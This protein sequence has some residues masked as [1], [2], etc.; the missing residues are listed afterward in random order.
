MDSH[1]RAGISRREII[2]RSAVAGGLVWTAPVI[3]D[4]LV[5]PAAALSN[6]CTGPSVTLSWIWILYTVNNKFYVTGFNNTDHKTACGAGGSNSNHG[7][8]CA[9][10]S[11]TSGY[12][13]QLNEFTGGA[14]TP[15]D[16]EL[17]FG[18]GGCAAATREDWE[19]QGDVDC[20]SFIAFN[21][22]K[23]FSQGGA[24]I[25]AAVGFGANTLRSI[26]PNNG[27]TGNFVCGIE[28]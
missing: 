16:G 24:V 5:S 27:Q 18:Q 14:P 11:A 12:S 22:G 19:L 6:Q 3:L 17:L 23:I 15:G 25:L 20:A 10:C 2:K 13:M 28:L 8:K 4:S 26:C 21:N 1:E 9:D 7:T